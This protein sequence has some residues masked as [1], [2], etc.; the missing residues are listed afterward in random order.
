M[1]LYCG[2]INQT[3]AILPL[4]AQVISHHTDIWDLSASIRKKRGSGPFHQVIKRND[5]SCIIKTVPPNR[6]HSNVWWGVISHWPFRPCVLRKEEILKLLT[7][8]GGSGKKKGRE[9]K[10]ECINSRMLCFKW[11][12]IGWFY[13][14]GVL[15]W[16]RVVIKVCWWGY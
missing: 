4:V 15:M 14:F 6:F 10:S 1:C 12:W 11:A 13:V 16:D 2:C 9:K 5:E 3:R 8:V 7:C